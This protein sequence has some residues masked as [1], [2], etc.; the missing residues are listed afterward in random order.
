M[1]ILLR[2]PDKFRQPV[3][4]FDA[5][6]RREDAGPDKAWPVLHLFKD[7]AEIIPQ[8]TQGEQLHAAKSEDQEYPGRNAARSCE[9]TLNRNYANGIRL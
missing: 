3:P 6:L 9:R 2:L 7:L 8:D 4:A 1:G 5:L